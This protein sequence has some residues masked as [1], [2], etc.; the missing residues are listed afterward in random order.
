MPPNEV[1]AD[2][3]NRAGRA[4]VAA[5]VAVSGWSSGVRADVVSDTNP[6]PGITLIKR[7]DQMT[8]PTRQVKMNIVF[9]DLGATSPVR[10]KLTPPR[11]DSRRPCLRRRCPGFRG[12]PCRRCSKSSD[13]PPCST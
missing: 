2:M 3:F 5:A 10:F 12:R 11:R 13:S 9:V 8:G 7:T 4:L 6:Y 1:E